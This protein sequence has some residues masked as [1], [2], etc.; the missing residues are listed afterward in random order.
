M[1]KHNPQISQSENNFDASG[2]H[3]PIRVS[4]GALRTPRTPLAT[5]LT[6]VSCKT[7]PTHTATKP[8]RGGEGELPEDLR[9]VIDP[10]TA[11][12]RSALFYLIQHYSRLTV[13]RVNLRSPVS[14][15]VSFGGRAMANSLD[16]RIEQRSRSSFEL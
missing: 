14:Q 8:T 11:S 6:V 1:F 7:L 10:L 12:A 5:P 4:P 16:V 9:A 3:P 15:K 13:K 2:F